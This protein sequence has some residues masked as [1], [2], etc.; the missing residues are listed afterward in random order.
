MRLSLQDN[1]KQGEY[2]K[3]HDQTNGDVEKYLLRP[4][5]L[6]E[7]RAFATKHALQAA[8]FGLQYDQGDQSNGE[9]N[10]DDIEISS[11]CDPSLR[12]C[13]ISNWAALCPSAAPL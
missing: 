1:A 5:T 2:E 8:A 10:L 12:I 3:N 4:P 6:G 13:C 9:D 7:N 11:Q